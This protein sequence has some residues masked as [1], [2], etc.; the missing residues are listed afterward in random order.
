MLYD[1]GNAL[2][3]RLPT[4]TS[5]FVGVM[6]FIVIAVLVSGVAGVLRAVFPASSA[7][8]FVD[9]HLFEIII[10]TLV[11]FV[12]YSVGLSFWQAFFP[13]KAER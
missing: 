4:G 13:P 9:A 3:E 11:V 7:T 5:R 6:Y 8:T 10:W 12:A 1:A 2:G